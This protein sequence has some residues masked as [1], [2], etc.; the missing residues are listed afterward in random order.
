MKN[1][2]QGSTPIRNRDAAYPQCIGTACAG[3]SERQSI[4]HE[5]PE[6]KYYPN[7]K[8]GGMEC[9]VIESVHPWT[10]EDEVRAQTGFALPAGKPIA[11]APP[12][13]SPSGPDAASKRRTGSE[14][15]LKTMLAAPV[16][17]TSS[18]SCGRLYPA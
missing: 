2:R 6:V 8:F 16:G 10:T 3:G 11:T 15:S 18:R 14:V 5:E 12:S 1:S 13:G 7:A 17:S 9:Q 4:K